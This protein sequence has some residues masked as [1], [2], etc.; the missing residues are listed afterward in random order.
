MLSSAVRP[1]TLDE[2]DAFQIAPGAELFEL[3]RL[4]LL[5]EVPVAV[6]HNRL[7]LR[8][9]PRAPEIDFRVASLYASLEQ[10]GN[11]LLRGD[12]QIEARAASDEEAAQLALAPA[13]PVLVS[14]ERVAGRDRRSVTIGCTVYRSDRH[15]FLLTFTRTPPPPPA[16]AP[17]GA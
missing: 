7:P 13:S 3:R 8:L 12:F 5:D 15:R 17:R 10:A 14:T 11:A 9:L 16:G 2:A 4:R 1:A 6:D